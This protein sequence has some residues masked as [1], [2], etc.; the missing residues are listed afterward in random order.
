MCMHN[1]NKNTIFTSYRGNIVIVMIST[2][3]IQIYKYT[4]IHYNI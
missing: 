1:N 3:I 2:A 4:N